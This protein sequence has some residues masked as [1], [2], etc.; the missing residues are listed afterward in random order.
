MEI[1]EGEYV[2]CSGHQQCIKSWAT[3]EKSDCRALGRACTCVTQRALTSFG[4]PTFTMVRL[5]WYVI[6][7]LKMYNS[8][9]KGYNNDT[10]N[11]VL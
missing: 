1:G 4:D 8:A 11:V 3:R 7:R 5:R 6:A 10:S 9:S 2:S